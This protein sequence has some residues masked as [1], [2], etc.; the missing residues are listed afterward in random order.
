ML[1]TQSYPYKLDKDGV[2]LLAECGD[3]VEPLYAIR[4][5]HAGERFISTHNRLLNR[6]V[7]KEHSLLYAGDLPVFDFGTTLVENRHDPAMISLGEFQF[8]RVREGVEQPLEHAA[9]I[10]ARHIPSGTCWTI[11]PNTQEPVRFILSA[12]LLPL[13]GIGVSLQ[14]DGKDC[15]ETLKLVVSRQRTAT[16]NTSSAW[17]NEDSLPVYCTINRL[18]ISWADAAF[19]I[20]GE[21]IGEKARVL[22]WGDVIAC[23]QDDDRRIVINFRLTSDRQMAAQVVH[24]PLGEPFPEE[25]FCRS[26]FALSQMR[27]EEETRFAH[28]LQRAHLSC[29]DPFL[30]GGFANS[31]LNL[32]YI[33]VGKAW[34]ES[35]QWWGCYWTNNFQISAAVAL[36]DWKRAREALL[37]F[38]TISEGYGSTS[39]TGEVLEKRYLEDGTYATAY[40]GMPYYL[41]QFQ[42][43]IDASGD[44]NLLNAVIETIHQNNLSMIARCDPDGDGL[45]GWHKGCNAFLYQADE[46]AIP[47]NG[48]SPS[49]LIARGFEQLSRLLENNGRWEL[50]DFYQKTAQA[51]WK[52]LDTLWD[53]RGYYL[54]AIDLQGTRIEP[55]YYTDLVFPALYADVPTPR[56]ILSL[57]Y[58][59]DRLVYRSEQTGLALMRVGDLKPDMFGNSN[60]MPVQMAEA[61]LALFEMGMS[62]PAYELL[63][64]CGLAGSVFTGA[65]GSAPERLSVEGRGEAR[66]PLHRCTSYEGGSG[67]SCTCKRTE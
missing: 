15:E 12:Y 31:V 62:Q 32:D 63:C 7:R 22:L 60:P 50:A 6:A 37:F 64:S 13:N 19:E 25:W 4:E 36:E 61:A 38:G 1:K 30:E 54:E 27:M 2:S 55:H 59:L 23:S 41:Q 20:Y 18:T 46:L 49:I 65:P 26:P 42:Q 66:E 3:A 10:Q 40:D 24:A 48:T 44:S 51:T 58:L 21:N 11:V 57:L 14:V 43:Y 52:R 67:Q 8:F 35:G 28:I 34:L 17:F 56:K 47:G 39:P 33:H 29:G 9:H 16:R 5:E 45:Y 53:E